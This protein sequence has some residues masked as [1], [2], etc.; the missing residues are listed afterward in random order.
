MAYVNETPT[1]EQI[2][3]HGLP[4]SPQTQRYWTVDHERGDFLVVEVLPGTSG[5][6]PP[7]AQLTLELDGRRYRAL[8][9]AGRGSA[10]LGEIPFIVEWGPIER[11]HRVQ[12][13]AVEEVPRFAWRH[14][15]MSEPVLGGL[16]LNTFLARL[17]EALHAYGAGEVGPLV[18]GPV[19]VRF[20][21]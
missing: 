19:L 4:F 13:D 14:A 20:Q 9:T 10:A 6:H 21:F 3:R 17:K 1:E 5:R 11:I 16:T 18:A 8:L 7:L 2:Q 15:D 12:G